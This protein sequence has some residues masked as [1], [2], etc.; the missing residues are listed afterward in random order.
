MLVTLAATGCDPSATT[1]S[2]AGFPKVTIRSG[3]DSMITSPDSVLTV[4]G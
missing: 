2:N 4:T 1:F 3:A